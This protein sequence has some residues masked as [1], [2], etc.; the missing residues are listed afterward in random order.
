MENFEEKFVFFD[1]IYKKLTSKNRDAAS[2]RDKRYCSIKIIQEVL[3][4]LFERSG[5]DAITAQPTR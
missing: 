4:I 5:Q 1:L 2:I 3:P